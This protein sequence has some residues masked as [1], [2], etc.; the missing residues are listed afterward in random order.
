[1]QFTYIEV[2]EY[3]TNKVVRRIDVS[4]KPPRTIERIEDGININLDVSRFYTRI[5]KVEE[6]LEAVLQ[7]WF[8]SCH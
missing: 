8:N 1:M 7:E 2:L 3:D 6:K 5:V 4:S